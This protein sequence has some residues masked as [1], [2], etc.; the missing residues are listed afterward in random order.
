MQLQISVNKNNV[1]FID[2]NFYGNGKTKP[3]KNYFK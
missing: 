3:K 2:A 1:I